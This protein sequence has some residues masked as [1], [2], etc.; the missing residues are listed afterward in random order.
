MTSF[1]NCQSAEVQLDNIQSEQLRAKEV[2]HYLSVI[3]ENDASLKSL[4]TLLASLCKVPIS[5]VSLV[6]SEHIWIKAHHGIEASCLPREGA[7]CAKAIDCN[8]E[9]FAVPNTLEDPDFQA[10]PLVANAPNIRFYAAAPFYGKDG[11]AIGTLWIMDTKPIEI[12]EDMSTILKSMSAYVAQFLDNIYSCEITQMPNR[13]S[14]IRRLQGIMNQSA[15]KV[16]IGSIHIQRLRHV[17]NIYGAAFRDELVN[18]ISKRIIDWNN[19]RWLL[20]HFGNGNFAFACFGTDSKSDVANLLSMLSV[21]VTLSGVTISVTVNIGIATAYAGEATAAALTDMAELASIEKKR[22]GVANVHFRDAFTSNQQMAMDIRASLHQD[23][24]DNY[25]TPYYQPQVDMASGE[26]V[27]FEAL[28]RWQNTRFQST[29]VWEVLKVVEDMGMTPVL[30]ILM[31]KKVCEDIAIWK[32]QGLNVPQ[33]STNIS[34]TTLLTKQLETELEQILKANGLTQSAI[35]LEITED[36]LPLDDK[37]LSTHITSLR[38]AGFNIAIDDFGTGTSNIATIANIDCH[39]LKVDRQF[40]HGVALNEHVAALL[41]LIK[42]TA[43]SMNLPLLVEGVEAQDD[44][45]WLS[46]MD[47]NLIQGWY[48]AKA[49][50][51]RLMPSILTQ[52]AQGNPG[53]TRNSKAEHLRCMLAQICRGEMLT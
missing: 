9:L 7:F 39:L 34:R 12:T 1:T 11:F 37:L 47:I 48:F 21:P 10:N 13:V 17:T 40:V 33:I 6:D 3:Q 19:S 20:A 24:S 41:R 46:D 14:F 28:M 49:M 44:L 18:T 38:S 4:S 43:D 52:M 26:I 29:P 15:E 2:E 35:E 27:G 42:G 36:G 50:P 45:D 53:T 30:D 32:S 22:S 31:F 8:E 16:S 51:S 23:E 25:L 5:G